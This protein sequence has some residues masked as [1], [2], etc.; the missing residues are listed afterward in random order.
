MLLGRTKT[1]TKGGSAP[2]EEEEFSVHDEIYWCRQKTGC[3]RVICTV[4]GWLA[5]PGCNI[6]TITETVLVGTAT[7]K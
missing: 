4:V 5:T 7:V 2:D 6:T 1:P 3:G